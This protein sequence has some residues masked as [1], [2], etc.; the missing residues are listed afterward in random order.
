MH[1][2]KRQYK[3]NDYNVQCEENDEQIAK[4]NTHTHAYTPKNTNTVNIYFLKKEIL[5]VKGA[6]KKCSNACYCWEGQNQKEKTKITYFLTKH[7][8]FWRTIVK[9]D[10]LKF[11]FCY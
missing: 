1:D 2:R 3:P 11:F 10:H 6:Y 9:K 8:I 7:E 4:K 5:Y